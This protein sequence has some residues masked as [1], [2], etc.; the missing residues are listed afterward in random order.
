M[1]NKKNKLSVAIFLF[2]KTKFIRI[3]DY[4]PNNT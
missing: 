1:L 4:N 3:A 2:I